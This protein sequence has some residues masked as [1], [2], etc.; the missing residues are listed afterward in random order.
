MPESHAMPLQSQP[1]NHIQVPRCPALGC[2]GGMA[3]DPMQC[4]DGTGLEALRCPACGHRGF[5]AQDGIRV[6]FGGRHEH[7]ISY[8]PSTLTL[9][10]VF[11]G[12]ALVL[13]GERGLSPAQAAVYAAQWALLSGQVAGTVH[14]FLE[15]PALSRCYEHFCGHSRDV[16]SG[17]APE[18]SRG[19]N[20]GFA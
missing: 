11:S 10:I 14:M 13:F 9:T 1:Q 20:Q 8:G 12:A 3:S 15:S 19:Q 16:L 17:E 6:L 2:G 7:V 5:Q 4:L 18:I